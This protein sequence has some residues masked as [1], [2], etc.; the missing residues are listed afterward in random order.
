MKPGLIVL[1]AIRN[2]TCE[3]VAFRKICK[4]SYT[5]SDLRDKGTLTVA[6]DGTGF[7]AS[8]AT[9]S[10][11]VSTRDS[12]ISGSNLALALAQL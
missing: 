3:F 12:S 7:I 1:C 9:R 5:S 10:A 8:S 2:L 4:G 6:E 11:E